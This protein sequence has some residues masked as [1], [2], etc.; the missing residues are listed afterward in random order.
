M[1][2]LDE[3]LVTDRSGNREDARKAAVALRND[4]G[5]LPGLT[6]YIGNIE[7]RLMRPNDANATTS[8]LAA[9]DV[10]PAIA[11]PAYDQM[12]R[13]YSRTRD[14]V[15]AIN[16]FSKAAACDPF[17]GEYFYHWAEALRRRG[18]PEESLGVFDK[19]LRRLSM[20]I[21]NETLRQTVAL[22][23]RL[24]AIEI[25]EG[26]KFKDEWDEHLKAPAPSGDWL[27]TAAALALQENRIADAVDP[28]QKAK[29]ALPPLQYEDHLVT[30]SSADSPFRI[31]I[32]PSCSPKTAR[33][34]ARRK[35]G[36]FHRSLRKKT[37]RNNA[38][39]RVGR[40]PGPG[41]AGELGVNPFAALGKDM[42]FFAD[43]EF[44]IT[45]ALS[46]GA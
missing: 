30:I 7:T 27:L 5:P 1:T 12:G 8:G 18:K 24:A 42:D 41:A 35:T 4:F 46:A 10:A 23:W 9:P 39:R 20:S 19:A 6:L 3:I 2:R 37:G 13:V 17:R 36:L 21:E 31:P 15:Q 28:L 44:V 26:P 29:A 25:G 43:G 33:K 14:F 45:L 34:K 11:A 32:A 16:D 38:F 22:K 40:H